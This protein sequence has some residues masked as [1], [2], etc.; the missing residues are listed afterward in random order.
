M[1]KFIED[2]ITKAGLLPLLTAHR[3]G[4]EATVLAALPVLQ[5]TDLLVL[6]AVADILRAEDSGT[7]VHIYENAAEGVTWVAPVTSELDTLRAV[8]IARITG[9]LNARIGI[10]WSQTGME[11]AQVA[12]GFGASD[13]RGPITRRSGLPILEDE[14]QKV[15]GQGM[16]EYRSIKKKEISDLVTHAGRQPVFVEDQRVHQ[17][18]VEVQS[19]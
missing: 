4:D 3:A 2:A 12:L 14:V 6:G 16:V 9:S 17:P 10:D 18:T 13:W 7:T 1:S 5:K 11:L 15:K 19:V 8:A